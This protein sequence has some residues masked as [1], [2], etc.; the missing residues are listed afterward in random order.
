M[1]SRSRRIAAVFVRQW[2]GALWES[3]LGLA[4]RAAR[5]QAF[6][7]RT[8]MALVE[9]GPTWVKIGQMA[10]VR[11]DV[12]PTELVF[13]L[14]KL[15]D[16]V[17]PIDF[18]EIEEV[19]AE[20]FGRPAEELFAGIDPEPIAAASIAQVHPA[21]LA[22][23]ARPVWGDELPA[24]AEVVLKVVRPGGREAIVE[25][26]RVARKAIGLLKRL[27]ALKRFDAD[28]LLSEFEASLH[29]ELD[30]R[31]EARVA[32]RF[33]FN[34]RDDP[35]VLVPRVVWKRTGL[36][37]MTMERL[38]GWRLSE[39]EHADAAGVDAKAL[40]I[41]GATAFMRMVMVD[42]L[43]HADLHH[44]NLF[45]TPDSRIAYLDFGIHGTLTPAER[46]DVAQVMTA[47]VYRDPDR[48]LRYSAG[49][50]VVVP[51]E[52]RE[53]IKRELGELMDR[54]ATK[55]GGSP[56]VK[57]FGIGFLSML[58]RHG[59]DI[60]VGYGLLV[61]SLATVEG[62]ARGLYP[63]IDIMDT[64]KPFV[65]GLLAKHYADPARVRERMP[66]AFR[67]AI[68]ELLA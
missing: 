20:E 26:L 50:G 9:L 15:Q 2:A 42:G 1:A 29:R 35:T 52:K 12:F 3:R 39:L 59:I 60:P 67:A 46:Q 53:A 19:I 23:A 48:A 63:D 5:R 49:L 58:A 57:G 36:R 25:D 47:F 62:V 22:E 61:K 41:H 11:P 14:E 13:E 66:D 28:K 65:T 40:A 51:D 4:G 44:A 45:V 64:A 43:F 54:I 38:P 16:S 6:A 33:A 8:R 37:V 18:A 27:G 68:R 24:G 30:L 21:T 56:D 55:T 32:D 10:S 31:K 17:P 34:F 7:R